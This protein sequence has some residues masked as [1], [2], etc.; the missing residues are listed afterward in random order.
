M[1]TAFYLW[2]MHRPPSDL[3]AAIKEQFDVVQTLDPQRS[4]I[5]FLVATIKDSK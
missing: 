5:Y 3:S 2:S 4:I 1:N